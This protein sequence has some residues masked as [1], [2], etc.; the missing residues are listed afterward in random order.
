M[1]RS[2]SMNDQSSGSESTICWKV[3]ARAMR[4]AEY[5][6]SVAATDTLA[7]EHATLVE[8]CGL[9]DRS[10]RGKLALTG[11]EAASFLEGQVTNAITALA[12]GEGAY[13]AFLTHK[14]KMLGD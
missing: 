3:S 11:S 7:A 6:R 5:P 9:V 2:M 13:A 8:G 14:G 1:R 4:G 10:E 12:A